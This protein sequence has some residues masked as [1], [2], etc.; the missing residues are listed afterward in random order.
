MSLNG[1]LGEWAWLGRDRGTGICP[2]VLWAGEGPM[3]ART[4]GASPLP[5]CLAVPD[6]LENTAHHG[7]KGGVSGSSQGLQD[8][9]H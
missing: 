5:V 7:G 1:W 8:G 4:W 3:V 9:S 6:C 2:V